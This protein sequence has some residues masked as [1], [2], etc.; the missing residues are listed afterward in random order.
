MREYFYSLSTDKK[1]GF[2][3]R[4]IKF[5]LYLLSLIY[6]AIVSAM[7]FFYDILSKGLP[8]RVISVGN[9]TWGGTGKTPLVEIIAGYIKNQ[10]YNIAILSRGYKRKPGSGIKDY[11][12]IG[13]EPYM[14]KMRLKDIPVIVDANRMRAA[15]IALN[16]YKVDAVIL[17]DGFQQWRIKKDLEIVNIDATNPFG[18]CHLIPRGILRQ[19][20]RSLSRADVFVLTK[21]DISQDTRKIKEALRRF[22]P[23]ALIFESVH[24][25]DGFYKL[26]FNQE[27]LGIDM[28]KG[29]VVSS[30]CGIAD[31]AYFEHILL[32]LGASIG[33]SF[34][35]PDHYPYS[36]K[37]LKD[38]IEK[39]RQ[40]NIDIIV[41]TEKDAARISHLA[42][43]DLKRVFYVLRIRLKITTDEEGFYNRLLGLFAR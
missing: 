1:T 14:L 4:V 16:D 38:I 9:I 29:R 19:P 33:L 28:I 17:D 23:S 13:D 12:W 27:M 40:K 39:S 3:A 35:F 21:T 10:G 30:V 11:N 2:I 6:G 32:G 20:L 18:N 25:P 26:G 31:P 36:A 37:D 15:K 42:T 43:D 34:K 8:C 22:N 5:I 24:K 41:T 7:I